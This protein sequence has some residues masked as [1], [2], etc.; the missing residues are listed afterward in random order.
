M[1]Y[2][3]EFK[4]SK[5]SRLL[6]N[7]NSN[8]LIH[9]ISFEHSPKGAAF[10]LRSIKLDHNIPTDRLTFNEHADF[11]KWIMSIKIDIYLHN[12]IYYSG[13]AVDALLRDNTLTIKTDHTLFIRV[14]HD[15]LPIG[16]VFNSVL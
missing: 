8:I 10:Y 6:I 2:H 9:D 16:K 4:K 12:R 13:N 14:S 11:Q 3:E 15:R 5:S 7:A 1:P